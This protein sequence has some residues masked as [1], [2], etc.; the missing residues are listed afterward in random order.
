MRRLMLLMLGLLML[1]ACGLSSTA[2]ATPT[3]VP[4][5]PTTAST[6]RPTRP[7]VGAQTPPTKPPLAD[8][9]L[10]TLGSSSSTALDRV[11]DDFSDPGSGWDVTSSQKG[12]VGYVDGAYLIQVNEVDYSLWANPDH[13]FDD[14]FAVVD[15]QLTADSAPADMGV[16]CRYQDADNFI[17]GDITSDGFY[18]INQV[19]AGDLS[20]LTGGGKLQSSDVIQ[21]GARA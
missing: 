13:T 1:L 9:P 4:L 15:T 14:V 2:P 3:R 19:K 8:E 18:G 21:Q 17:Y 16:I 20:I 5:M 11:V 10:A 7:P 6:A 12:S